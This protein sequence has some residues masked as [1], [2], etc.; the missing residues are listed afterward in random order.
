MLMIQ[1][2][3][4]L[5]FV[6]HCSVL[7]SITKQ[8]FCVQ[9]KCSLVL[10][11]ERRII[12]SCIIF[13]SNLTPGTPH[14]RE[15]S[16]ITN[17]PTRAEERNRSLIRVFWMFMV[18]HSVQTPIKISVPNM[19]F[20]HEFLEYVKVTLGIRTCDLEEHMCAHSC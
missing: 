20:R 15:P 12:T 16:H 18:A 2:Y 10:R 14:K 7:Q 6:V 8:S 1:L 9:N 5:T 11:N 13:I 19:C 4:C 3:N 17:V